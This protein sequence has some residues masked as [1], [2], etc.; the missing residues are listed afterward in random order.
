M[1]KHLALLLFLLAPAVLLAQEEEE[2]G[3]IEYKS[4]EQ[5]EYY[6]ERVENYQP[7]KPLDK[8]EILDYTNDFFGIKEIKDFTPYQ[9]AEEHQRFYYESLRSRFDSCQELATKVDKRQ[10]IKYE[11]RDSVEVI[12]YKSYEFSLASEPSVYVAYS[13]DNG[14][15]W[16]FYYTGI[17]YCQPLCF[18]PL[19]KLPLF[20]DKGQLQLEVCLLRQ[21]SPL[22]L[23]HAADYELVKDGLVVTIDLSMLRKD[24]DGDGL[25]DIEESR[26]K[27][28]P[29]NSDT[30]G[31]GVIDGLDLNP[32]MSVPRSEKTAIFE[33]L[34]NDYRSDTIHITIPEMCYANDKTNP[35]LIVTDNPDLQS[36]QPQSKRVIVFSTVEFEK[37]AKFYYP[38]RELH[39]S[40][41]FK[42]DDK[43]DA[44]L[45][46]ITTNNGGDEYLVKRIGNIWKKVCVST[47]IF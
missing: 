14:T 31:D 36:V 7:W 32:R 8:S 9:E 1:K 35:V 30:D 23:G 6:R 26:F 25:T 37:N 11:T 40:P 33:S 28:D 29:S 45:V 24:S 18:K 17:T 19:S 15:S 16:S 12:V 2:W 22:T 39:I 41:L 3:E 27:T 10:V 43:E 44:Y 5:D 46:S 42:V 21:V 34:V 13:S 47:W 4:K 20:N 38:M